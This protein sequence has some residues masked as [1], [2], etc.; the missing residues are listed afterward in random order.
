MPEMDGLEV[1]RQI[2]VQ[3]DAPRVV[4]LTLHDDLEYRR[5]AEALGADGFVTKPQLGRKLLDLLKSLPP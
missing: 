1:T 4:L 2:K 5:A 3:P